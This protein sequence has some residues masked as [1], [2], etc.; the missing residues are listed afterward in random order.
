MP[1]SRLPPPIFINGVVPSP[2]IIDL[3]SSLEELNVTF[4]SSQVTSKT[5]VRPQTERTVSGLDE[6]EIF[7]NYSA[8]PNIF[9]PPVELP[10]DN[11]KIQKVFL[12]TG[13]VTAKKFQQIEKKIE[14]DEF[15]DDFE[16]EATLNEV[17]EIEKNAEIDNSI[18]VLSRS[19]HSSQILQ[20]SNNRF[21]KG[22][23]ISQT[24]EDIDDE[25]D[26]E[27]DE[28]KDTE[29]MENSLMRHEEYDE[30][31]I[32]DSDDEL[33]STFIKTTDDM[34]RSAFNFDEF[35]TQKPQE[36]PKIA[37]KVPPQQIFMGFRSAKSDKPLTATSNLTNIQKK[38]ALADETIQKKLKDQKFDEKIDLIPFDVQTQANKTFSEIENLE[39]EVL[40]D[41]ETQLEFPKRSIPTATQQK[42]D[43]EFIENIINDFVTE[44]FMPISNSPRQQFPID[45]GGFKTAKGTKLTEVNNKDLID[46]F[47]KFDEKV[48]GEL[49]NNAGMPMLG[50]FKSAAGKKMEVKNKNILK[51]QL[52]KFEKVD[53]E[54]IA[55]IEIDEND[56][57]FAVKTVS[58]P[59]NNPIPAF[60]GEKK[61]LL[62]LDKI[63]RPSPPQV[64]SHSRLANQPK[65]AMLH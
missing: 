37:A 57:I 49:C 65:L 52:E 42:R 44:D 60:G 29:A 31:I 15:D 56:D 11:E 50:G 62:N 38:F 64:V 9:G 28:V 3:Q 7:S 1:P 10:V 19:L 55:G 47:Y 25:F 43:Q 51:K 36:K 18:S 34:E 32:G 8:N 54:K 24:Y 14:A 12:T 58:A 30:S 21:D 45:F 23:E 4:S 16:S 41:L 22:I 40:N 53:N 46:D 59:S 27:P 48:M 20:S 39:L 13:F 5:I 2:Q 35:S 17:K 26:E 33:N 61:I 6:E 63:Y